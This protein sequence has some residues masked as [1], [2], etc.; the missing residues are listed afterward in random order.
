MPKTTGVG[1]IIMVGFRR[2]VRI[3]CNEKGRQRH[4]FVD[5]E[6]VGFPNNCKLL[7][8]EPIKALPPIPFRKDPSN[9]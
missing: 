1:V 6:E 2:R 9:V 7:V 8:Y 3:K 4:Y 5:Q